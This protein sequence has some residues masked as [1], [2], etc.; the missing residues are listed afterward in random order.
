MPDS[1]GK[2]VDIFRC[3]FGQSE[4]IHFGGFKIPGAD[5]ASHGFDDKFIH[6]VKL[7]RLQLAAKAVDSQGK[8]DPPRELGLDI[9]LHVFGKAAA[10]P[11]SGGHS[12]QSFLMLF[13][14]KMVGLHLMISEIRKG[15]IC[16]IAD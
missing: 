8:A 3:D 9:V 13:Q 11:E 4:L 16:R 2:T 14:I 6:A 10:K 15:G 5:R 1:V 12:R 7:F